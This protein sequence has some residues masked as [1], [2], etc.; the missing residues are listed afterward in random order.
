MIEN[1]TG[2]LVW[3]LTTKARKETFWVDGNVLH[4]GCSGV[5]TCV[6]VCLLELLVLSTLK[7]DVFIGCKLYLIKVN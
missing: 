5:Y 4:L 3:E 7:W 2:G 6:C 1:S